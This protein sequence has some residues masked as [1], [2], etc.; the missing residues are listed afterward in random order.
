MFPRRTAR[1]NATQHISRECRK[2]RAT[3]A[4]LP[5]AF[6]LAVPVFG[7][8]AKDALLVLPVVVAGGV[9]VLVGEIECVGQLAVDVELQ[10]LIGGVADADGFG[11]HVA[12][13]MFE[14]G[15]RRLLRAVDTVEHLQ[16]TVGSVVVQ[17]VMDPSLKLRSL[18]DETEPHHGIERE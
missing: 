15:L 8:P 16:R 14:L 6:V 1:S 2:W 5:D 9:A 17:T 18:F 12:T 11:V 3:A 13:K 4:N 7:E 10:L